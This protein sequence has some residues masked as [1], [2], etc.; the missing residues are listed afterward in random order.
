MLVLVWF[1]NVPSGLIFCFDCFASFFAGYGVRNGNI[2]Y[3]SGPLHDL[4][5][6][7]A[8]AK[9]AER[10]TEYR[11]IK[12]YYTHPNYSLTNSRPINLH[13]ELGLGKFQV[14]R[15]H[16][17]KRAHQNLSLRSTAFRPDAWDEGLL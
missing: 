9:G 2:F 7:R 5:K 16:A 17:K 3:V 14:P 4:G 6:Y 11:A 13:R 15:H 8:I 10:E 12:S 1:R